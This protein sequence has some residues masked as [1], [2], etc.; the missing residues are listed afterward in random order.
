MFFEMPTVL[1]SHRRLFTGGVLCLI[2]ASMWTVMPVAATTSKVCPPDNGK[3]SGECPL[4]FDSDNPRKILRRITQGGV[5]CIKPMNAGSDSFGGKYLKCAVSGTPLI[6]RAYP[7]SGA[8]RSAWRGEPGASW[9]LNEFKRMA[10]DG[11][12]GIQLMAHRYTV[13]IWAADTPLTPERHGAL[14]RSLWAI[15]EMP[16]ISTLDKETGTSY[17][18]R[19][20]W[21]GKL[22]RSETA[23]Q[24][25]LWAGSE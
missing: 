21:K 19:F 6:I 12:A 18:T 2:T 8:F 5:Q 16:K 17:E 4:P 3:Y 15:L 7:T 23:C 9:T 24:S 11:C 10:W 13:E 22:R 14:L 20:V 1:K 25:G